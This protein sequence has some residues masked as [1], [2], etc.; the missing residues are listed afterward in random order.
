MPCIRVIQYWVNVHNIKP[1]F[2]DEVFEKLK[3]K[4]SLMTPEERQCVLMCDEMSIKKALEYN[5]KLML[6][7]VLK[8]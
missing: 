2:T 5:S 3:L 1:G 4:A 7:R 6:S 8:T